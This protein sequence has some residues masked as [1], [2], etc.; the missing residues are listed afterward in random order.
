MTLRRTPLAILFIIFSSL[1]FIAR[2]HAFVEI[3]DGSVT[4]LYHMNG[5]SSDSS[6]RG[7]HGADFGVTYVTG[8]I[9]KAWD[10]GANGGDRYTKVDT[11]VLDVARDFTASFWINLQDVSPSASTYIMFKRRGGIPDGFDGFGYASVFAPENLEFA[12]ASDATN[13]N[14]GIYW[15]PVENV[16]YWVVIRRSGSNTDLYMNNLLIGTIPESNTSPIAESW[17]FGCLVQQSQQC[18]GSAAK[19]FY[20]DEVVFTNNAISTST[21]FA[22]WNN[23]KGAEVCVA[24]KCGSMQF[25]ID[26]RSMFWIGI[27]VLVGLLAYYATRHSW[28][29]S[30]SF[31]KEKQQ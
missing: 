25:S 12:K 3:S 28:S 13:S 16:W 30:V 24:E 5:S 7:Y 19:R 26:H 1:F 17:Y 29:L 18:E 14:H 15:S 9:S 21:R 4:G 8:K 6:G 31:R 23:G 20:L 11:S 22:L 10:R 27:L 2:A